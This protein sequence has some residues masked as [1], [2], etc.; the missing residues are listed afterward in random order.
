MRGIEAI[1]RATATTATRTG[2]GGRIRSGGPFGSARRSSLWSGG[3]SG[4]AGGG[5]LWNGGPYGTAFLL[6]ALLLRLAFHTVRL[7]ENPGLPRLNSFTIGVRRPSL[8]TRVRARFPAGA[9]TGSTVWKIR[10]VEIAAVP[11]P[12]EDQP[13]AAILAEILPR[14]VVLDSSTRRNVLVAQITLALLFY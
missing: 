5:R 8:A 2:R 3:P 9:Y 14:L 4:T 13:C 6:L 12:L 7:L 1:R 11:A 10:L